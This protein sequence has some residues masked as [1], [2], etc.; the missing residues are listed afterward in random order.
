[1]KS[2]RSKHFRW[3]LECMS[4]YNRIRN[5]ERKRLVL[6]YYSNSKI[7]CVKCHESDILTLSID[8]I[9]GH[10]LEHL[11]SQNICGG[12]SLHRW[13]IKHN[14]PQGYQTLCMCCQFI[15]EAEASERRHICDTPSQARVARYRAKLKS[16]AINVY[17]NGTLRCECGFSDIRALTIDHIDGGGRSHRIKTAGSGGHNFYRWLKTH[18]YPSGYGVLCANCQMKKEITIEIKRPVLTSLPLEFG[19]I[20]KEKRIAN[21]IISAKSNCRKTNIIYA[22]LL[23]IVNK[24]RQSGKNL[25]EIA[26]FLNQSGYETRTNKPWTN[27]SVYRNLIDYPCKRDAKFANCQDSQM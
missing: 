25:K 9:D 21:A 24:M 3:C 16:D 12:N 5:L 8:H 22:T 20:T 26:C 23:P 10:G 13:L 2:Y 11:R 17:S 27:I 18:N 19:A 7:E 15:K 14:F 6:E 1:M 4:R